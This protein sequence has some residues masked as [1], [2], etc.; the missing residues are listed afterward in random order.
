MTSGLRAP[1]NVDQAQLQGPAPWFDER[2]ADGALEFKAQ[3]SAWHR[4]GGWRYAADANGTAET[5]ARFV[6]TRNVPGRTLLLLAA[7]CVVRRW[8]RAPAKRPLRACP[9]TRPD[10]ARYRQCRRDDEQPPELHAKQEQQQQQRTP[11]PAVVAAVGG[12]CGCLHAKPGPDAEGSAGPAQPPAE[13]GYRTPIR[14]TCGSRPRQPAGFARHVP[15]A[16]PALRQVGTRRARQHRQL[17]GGREP[18]FRSHSP[19]Q[20]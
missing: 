2:A 12:S 15:Q 20:P 8:V 10:H 18:G 4:A 6:A 11:N 3:R 13:R 1:F 17:L 7:Y 19:A 5:R 9:N 14:S 16:E